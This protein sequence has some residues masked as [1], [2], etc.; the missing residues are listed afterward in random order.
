MTP[1]TP[2]G[3]PP[4]Q[5]LPAHCS[6]L[7][8]TNQPGPKIPPTTCASGTDD[9]VLQEVVGLPDHLARPEGL[10]DFTQVLAA[11][12]FE[13]RFDNKLVCVNLEPGP[14]WQDATCLVLDKD[15]QP[16]RGHRPHRLL[17]RKGRRRATTG[18]TWRTS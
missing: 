3:D 15:T 6:N 12:E 9:A 8:L 11:F 17:H 5:K 7:F 10:E 13:V 1:V 16:A 2:G 4:I 14:E 18:C